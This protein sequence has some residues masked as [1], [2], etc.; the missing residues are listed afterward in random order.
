MNNCQSKLNF[1]KAGKTFDIR[2]FKIPKYDVS[3]H[4]TIAGFWVIALPY[5]Q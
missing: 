4:E 5:Y 2:F 3:N 1:L